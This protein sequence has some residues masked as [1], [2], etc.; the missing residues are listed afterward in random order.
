MLSGPFYCDSVCIEKKLTFWYW[1][2]K[3]SHFSS[4]HA[5][6]ELKRIMSVFFNLLSIR[7][8][9]RA[10][11]FTNKNP[12]KNTKHKKWFIANRRDQL[13]IVVWDQWVMKC[14]PLNVQNI[15]LNFISTAFCGC[16][17]ST[18]HTPHRAHIR[19]FNSLL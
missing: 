10:L 6:F 16:N 18:Q 17:T 14:M 1:Y 13:N 5:N 9:Y 12:V 3:R 2:V 11:L 8:L 19:S 4:L 7:T 15:I